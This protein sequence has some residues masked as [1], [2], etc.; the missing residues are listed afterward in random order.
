MVSLF[1]TG[2]LPSKF[3]IF[4]ARQKK[5]YSFLKKLEIRQLDSQRDWPIVYGLS[6]VLV[7]LKPNIF[8]KV[9]I[10]LLHHLVFL[11]EHNKGQIK[12]KAV[13]LRRRF[14]HKTNEQICFVRSEKQKGKQNKFVCLFFF[15]RIYG[16]PICVRFYMTFTK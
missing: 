3:F 11:P 5:C 6:F 8:E 2:Q 10:F 13:W 1:N 9:F 12:L 16:T 7:L 4:W 15:G 14:F